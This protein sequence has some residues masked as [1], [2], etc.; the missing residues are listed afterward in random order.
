MRLAIT[1]V[2]LRE[3]NAFVGV[4]HRH[5]GPV[6]GHGF[7]IGAARAG[8]LVGVVIVGRPV[9]R[10]WDHRVIAEITRLATDGTRNACSFL[11]GAARRAALAIGYRSVITYTLA[12]ESGASLRAAGFRFVR[13]VPG[14]SWSCTSRPRV[15]KHPTEDKHLWAAG[16]PLPE[17]QRRVA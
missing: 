6:R 11:Y 9:S 13:V 16:D 12:S 1:R 15:D 3:A 8:T 10:G 7:S 4:V 14:R 2:H 17:E 5:H